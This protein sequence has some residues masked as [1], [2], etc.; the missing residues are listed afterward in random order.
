[1]IT[2]L[3]A[4]EEIRKI[5]QHNRENGESDLRGILH[6]ISGLKTSIQ[7]GK[8]LAEIQQEQELDEN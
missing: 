2:A 5:V 7:Q 1:M 4:L 3:E 6:A 8:T